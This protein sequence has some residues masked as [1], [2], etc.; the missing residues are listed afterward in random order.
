MKD[1]TKSYEYFYILHVKLAPYLLAM[2]EI[3][4][5]NYL[6]F[7]NRRNIPTFWRISV[8]NDEGRFNH[9]SNQIFQNV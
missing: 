2:E 6:Q 5:L 7:T 4:C 8:E 3:T 1:L 9:N